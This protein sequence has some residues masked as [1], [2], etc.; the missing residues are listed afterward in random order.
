MKLLLSVVV[1]SAVMIILAKFNRNRHPGWYVAV[2][3][4]TAI[5]VAVLVFQLFNM[6]NP[7]TEAQ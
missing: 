3:V 4:I 6:E 1:F 2:A 5:Q 7:I